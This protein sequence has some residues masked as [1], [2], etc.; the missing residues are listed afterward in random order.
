[1]NKRSPSVSVIITCYNYAEFVEEAIRSVLDQTYKNIEFVI[2]D[3]GSTD[4]SLE[5]INKYKDSAKVIS[6]PNKGIVYTRNEALGLAT[7]KYLCF[8][9]ADDYF[10]PDY[11]E[12]SVR[13]AEEYG[14]D[15]VFP[16]WHVFGDTEY[17]TDF[18]EF[19]VQLLIRQE[20]HCT[21]ESLIRRSA[22]GKHAFESEQVAED[23]D[24]FLGLA[25][26]GRKFKLAKDNFINYR[27]R[28]NTRGTSRPFWDDMY[29]FCNI[30]VKWSKK[31][32]EVVNPF[33]L[34][35]AVSKNRIE[36]LTQVIQD[37]DNHIESLGQAVKEKDQAVSDMLLLVL[38][39][40]E[41]WSFKIGQV[42]VYPM[43][44]AKRLVRSIMSLLKR[45]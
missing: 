29:H 18:A 32:P 31:Y 37:K 9:D 8:L 5:V 1:M 34:P 7:G 42:I 19:D 15:V 12:K 36:G 20:I 13:I 30:L 40:K 33:D 3:D 17:Y 6:R 14:A 39:L 28:Q 45:A 23:W 10:S 43:A 35:I 2:I 21:A 38:E 4:K 44:Q 41:S 24:F 26:D 27:V 22:I 16:N 11:V 25:L